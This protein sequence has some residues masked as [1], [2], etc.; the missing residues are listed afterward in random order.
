MA[1]DPRIAMGV[2]APNL[3]TSF[4]LFQNTLNNIQ[5]RKMNDQ[6]MAQ[7]EL[8]NPLRVQEAQQVVDSNT[9]AANVARQNQYFKSIADTKP[10]L[11]PLIQDNDTEGVLQFLDQRRKQLVSAGTSTE[12]TD[13]AIQ[14]ALSGDLQSIKQAYDTASQSVYGNP[15]ANTQ[16]KLQSSKILADGTSIQVLS[17]GDTRVTSARQLIQKDLL[18]S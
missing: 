10:V 18:M 12:T 14:L 13:E 9:N 7:N 16:V 3:Q 6:S 5:N 11:D 2:Q 17:N 8:I 1:I 15:L 4:N